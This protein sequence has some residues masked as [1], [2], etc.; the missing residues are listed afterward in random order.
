MQKKDLIIFGFKPHDLNTYHPMY[1][2]WGLF[3][4]LEKKYKINGSQSLNQ[5]VLDNNIKCFD[6]I[7]K[8]N[9]FLRFTDDTGTYKKINLFILGKYE[10]TKKRKVEYLNQN[11]TN[12]NKINKLKINVIGDTNKWDYFYDKIKFYKLLKKNKYNYYAKYSVLNIDDISSMRE[13][14]INFP[15]LLKE[16]KASGGNDS[17]LINTIEE[18][19]IKIGKIKRQ[20]ISNRIFKKKWFIVEFI[21]TRY[22]FGYYL[23]YR[24]LGIHNIPYF[25]YPNVSHYN[26]ITHVSEVDKI[27]IDDYNKTIKNSFQIYNDNYNLFKQI[28]KLLNNPFTAL[29]F[30]IDKNGKI[31]FS[32]CEL[33][34]GPSQK[35]I[36]NQIYHFNLD[37][38]HFE[39]IRDNI[40]SKYYTFDDVFL[41]YNDN[42]EYVS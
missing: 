41:N 12:W 16:A 15:V 38:K 34:Y 7:K 23:S 30:L 37:D 11:I 27:T 26:P 2:K 21:D 5:Y 9:N 13:I 28:F 6:D 3:F 1:A 32:E 8:L 35:Y 4:S 14:E 29:D 22:Q 36:S 20:Y 33:K 10:Y 40:K 25:I 19:I 18:L 31:I 42:N 39:T 17:Y 24:V